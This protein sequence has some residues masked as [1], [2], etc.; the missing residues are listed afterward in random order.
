MVAPRARNEHGTI[1]YI[2]DAEADLTSIVNPQ[3]SAFALAMSEKTI[4]TFTGS[5]WEQV[6]GG[7]VDGR[8][9]QTNTITF[10]G[11]VV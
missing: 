8:V 9:I 10:G 1:E 6:G 11:N 3:V 2:V 5:I 4:W 7:S